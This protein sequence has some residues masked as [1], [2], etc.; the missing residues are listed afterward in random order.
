MAD[1]IG[2]NSYLPGRELTPPKG[3][4]CDGEFIEHLFPVTAKY[5]IVGETDSLGSELFDC[6]EACYVKYKQSSEEHG[7]VT[8]CCDWCKTGQ[9]EL[10]PMR[11]F[12]E[13]SHGPVY[14]VC[15]ACRKKQN[16]YIASE[17]AA[18]DDY[19]LHD[20]DPGLDD[21]PDHPWN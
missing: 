20:I 10:T 8:G 21:D 14:D 11:D 13:G 18:D 4:T 2:P 12:E 19:Y 16:D 5:R 15:S 7:P 3:Q 9:H 6:C 1:V 17:A